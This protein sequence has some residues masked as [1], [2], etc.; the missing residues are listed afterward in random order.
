MRESFEMKEAL[1]PSLELSASLVPSG[2]R[3]RLGDAA[4]KR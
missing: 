1:F 4:C 2:R 3:L